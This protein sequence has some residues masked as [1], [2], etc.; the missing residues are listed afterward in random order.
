M[1]LT[2][3]WIYECESVKG[4]LISLRLEEFLCKC[5]EERGENISYESF[6]ITTSLKVDNQFNW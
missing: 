4:K 6:L 3:Q 1:T 2:D 5:S